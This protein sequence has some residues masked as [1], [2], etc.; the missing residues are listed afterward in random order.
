MTENED[1]YARAH[2]FDKIVDGMLQTGMIKDSAELMEK[3]IQE[4]VKTSILI[5]NRAGGNAPRIARQ[6]AGE[7]LQDA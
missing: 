4:D 2:P 6:I 7:F 5:N 1:A 3:A